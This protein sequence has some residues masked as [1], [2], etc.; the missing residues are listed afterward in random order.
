MMV[1]VSVWP[2]VGLLGVNVTLSTLRS[3][4]AAVCTTTVRVVVFD[5]PS[6]S[7]TVSRAV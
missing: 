7:V 3:G 4:M 6:L 2:M 1:N 5:A